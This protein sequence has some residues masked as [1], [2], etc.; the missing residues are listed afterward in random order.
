MNILCVIDYLG[1]GGAQQQ[2]VNLAIGFKKKGHN[3][4]FLV[5]HSDT[6]F[7]KRLAENNI[8][9]T[10]IKE[11]NYLLR[12]LKLRKYIRNGNYCAVLSYLEAPNF[13]CE[14]AGFPKRKWNLVVGERSS[15]PNICISI[16]KIVFRW[17]LLLADH[18][19]ANS[20]T[21]IKLVRKLNPFLKK[22]QTHVIYNLIDLGEW[23]TLPNYIFKRNDCVKLVIAANH[24]A[25]KN[26]NG[27][28]LGINSLTPEEKGKI[29]IEWYGVALD[30]SKQKALELIEKYQLQSCFAFF[31]ETSKIKS[32][33]QN[34]DV[35]GIFSFY[36]GFPN[37]ICEGM[38]CGKPIIASAVSDIPYILE[39]GFNGFL[40][41]PN[42]SQSITL[43]LR[44]LI[45]TKPNELKEMGLLN[46][47]KAKELFDP[48]KI[49]DK[50]IHLLSKDKNPK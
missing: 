25:L 17:F 7:L 21:N 11:S 38:A 34:A 6:F 44:R 10:E 42:D 2:L 32:K 9:V 36:E 12:I 5:Y 4:S 22:K 46:R 1:S 20:H 14:I 18:V 41:N 26:L 43:A 48:E 3:V 37:I 19:V 27:L 40:C 50:Y 29:R 24:R 15:N 33:I 16:K 23:E 45:N 47:K 39:E 30:D 49:T 13:I 31:P 35:V 8:P 28:V